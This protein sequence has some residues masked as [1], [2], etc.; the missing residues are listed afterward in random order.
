MTKMINS[1][2]QEL[3]CRLARHQTNQMAGDLRKAGADLNKRHACRVA[4]RAD[5]HGDKAVDQFLDEAIK[6]ARAGH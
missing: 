2:V 1:F 6:I 4:L 3:T 5:G